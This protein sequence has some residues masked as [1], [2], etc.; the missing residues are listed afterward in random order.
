MWLYLKSPW[1]VSP[2]P[3]MIYP[4]LILSRLFLIS[5]TLS[6]FAGYFSEVLIHFGLIPEPGPTVL[7][8]YHPGRL[9]FFFGAVVIAPILEEFL[10]RAQLK[11]FSGML[12]FVAFATGLLFVI[13][14]GSYW[15]FLISPFIFFLLFV[16]YRCTLAGSMTR[17]FGFWKRLF[18][19]H[20]HFTAICFALIHLSNFQHG[21]ALLPLGILYT[22][23]QLV[24]GLIL[25]FTRMFYGL[26]YSI[27]LHSFYNLFF[28]ILFFLKQ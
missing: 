23:P 12:M 2:P 14:S 28:I 3:V 11:R 9:E 24:I 8:Q 13:P 16:I 7:D 18:P 4:V 10:F 21:A 20:F 1:L 19:W 27:L 25:G 5:I 22:L 17:K 6:F 26:K 15:A